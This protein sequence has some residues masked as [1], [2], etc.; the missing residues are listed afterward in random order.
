MPMAPNAM[1][2]MPPPMSHWLPN[3]ADSPASA[4][5]S[6]VHSRSTLYTPTLVMSANSAPTGAVAAL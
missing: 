6:S 5:N 2:S 4:P 1:V 3:S